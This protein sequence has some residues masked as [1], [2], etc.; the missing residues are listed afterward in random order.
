MILRT[1]ALI[2][3]FSAVAPV[4]AD[5]A[6]DI[7]TLVEGY[8]YIA[9]L[10]CIDCPY[11]Y[12]DTSNGENG[13]WTDRIDENALLLNISLPFDAAHLSVNNAPLLSDST[14][15]PRIYAFQVLQD[16]SEDDL[17]QKVEHSELDT[18]GP[19][20]GLSYGTS[21]HRLTNSTAMV[22]RFNIFSAYFPL[23]EAPTIINLNNSKQKVVELIFL[24]R[25]LHSSGD[26][27]PGWEIVTARLSEREK[28]GSKRRMRTMDFEDWDEF[29][30]KGSPSHLVTA[31]SKGLVAYASS[32]FWGLSMA[33]LG[34]VV[35][36][37]VV[38]V[39]CVLGWDWWSGGYEKV[40]NGESAGRRAGSKGS[41]TWTDVE[42]AKGRFLSASE[43]GMRGG[44]SVVGVGKND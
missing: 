8:N 11:L 39:A 19:T 36:F 42:K 37:V 18:T 17:R 29:G 13:P 43:L 27:G 10:P 32:G 3:L 12:Q 38:V 44:G 28:K 31:S 5:V 1:I 23:S 20:L 4:L 16:Y 2:A 9:K 7:I 15:L 30:R 26:V 40:Q 6:P 35:L 14:I 25:P 41:G 21:L 24:P 22:F 33:I 34:F